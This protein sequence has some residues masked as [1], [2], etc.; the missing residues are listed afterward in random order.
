MKYTVLLSFL[1][2]FSGQY[3]T[4]CSSVII[5]GKA[6]RD[7]RPLMWKNCDTD[8]LNHSLI[9]S[10]DKGLPLLGIVRNSS[11]DEATASIWTGTNAKGFS[12]MNTLSYNL[13][14]NRVTSSNGWVM[15][16]A[17]EVCG[18]VPDFKAFLDTLPKPLQ[19]ESNYG[20]IDAE[21]NA[22]YFE[23]YPDGYRMIDVNDP[24]TAPLGYLVYT[25]FSYTGFYDKGEGYIRY[26]TVMHQM[27]KQAPS[28]NFTPQWI[29]N[30]LARCF[31]HSLMDADF[32]DESTMASFK[33][34][35]IP[36]A[37]FIPRN[38]TASSTVVQGVRKGEN[39]ELTTMW[40]V[41]GYTPC[42]IAI[43]SWVKAGRDNAPLLM[44][45]GE[46]YTS[47]M[48][49]RALEL[50]ATVFDVSRGHGQSYLRFSKLHNREG[51]G[52][53]QQLAPVENEVFGMAAPWIDKWRQADSV[54]KAEVVELAAEISR[55]VDENF[56]I[57]Q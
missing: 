1:L 27:V 53:M 44:R 56:I 28:K 43:P 45:G 15:R 16:R 54:D 29:F 42:S 3:S 24:A 35:Y 8:N 18:N 48:C 57:N 52:Y 5:S 51:T 19:V 7:G 50:K 37:D 12:I 4:A 22:A 21:G 26:Q 25:N 36:D 17:L 38:S 31:Y 32:T 11:A 47:Q 49:N 33:N 40:T 55:F 46:N 6:T 20:V 30:K 14:E 39:P 13:T 41:L 2:S 34:G 23:T 10:D 9:Y